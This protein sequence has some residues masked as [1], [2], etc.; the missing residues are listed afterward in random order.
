VNLTADEF[1]IGGSH[2]L[3]NLRRLEFG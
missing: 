1:E 3:P 2:C